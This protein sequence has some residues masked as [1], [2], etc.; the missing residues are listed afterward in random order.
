MAFQNLLAL[1]CLEVPQTQRLILASACQ[2]A[3]IWMKCGGTHAV[4]MSLQDM[5]A[6]A[7]L[8]LPD[9]DRPIIATTGKQTPIGAEDHGPDPTGMIL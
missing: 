3:S 1:A 7:G 4:A 8:R 2:V 5:Q 6:R 9:A